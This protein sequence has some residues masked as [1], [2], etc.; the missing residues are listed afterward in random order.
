MEYSH[1]KQLE[2][3]KLVYNQQ[4]ANLENPLRGHDNTYITLAEMIGRG[5]M[6]GVAQ[7][8]AIDH[9]SILGLECNLEMFN[10]MIII[11]NEYQMGL[12]STED[13][14][15]DVV[16]ALV[17]QQHIDLYLHPTDYQVVVGPLQCECNHP[18]LTNEDWV[19][20]REHSDQRI[21][22]CDCWHFQADTECCYCGRGKQDAVLAD[23]SASITSI[24][25][26]WQKNA[27]TEGSP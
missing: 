14:L 7:G 10:R 6:L 27:K 13:W 2:S 23:L 9:T 17:N 26:F 20:Q 12:T 24:L 4:S 11:N 18:E 1:T 15:L 19:W 16:L 25:D 22:H 5:G 3:Y 21:W 8:T